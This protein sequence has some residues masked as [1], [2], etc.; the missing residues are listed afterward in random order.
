MQ[1]DEKEGR[2]PLAARIPYPGEAWIIN[3]SL[4]DEETVGETK[5]RFIPVFELL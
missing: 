3:L 2:G 4:R 5:V 1:G